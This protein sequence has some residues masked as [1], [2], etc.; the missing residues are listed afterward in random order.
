MNKNYTAF[1]DRMIKRYEGGYGWDRADPGGPTKYGVTCFDYAASKG[2]KMNSM[3]E[4]APRV[5][6]MSLA[7]AEGIYRKKY[8]TGVAFDQL[9]GGSDCV[10]F[11]YGVNSG[12]SRPV[13]VAQALVKQKQ[14]GKMSPELV[15][16]INKL[17]AKWFVKAMNQERLA[18]MH[19][20]RGGSAWATFGKGWGARVSDL[21]KYAL[22]IA[23][24]VAVL[25]PMSGPVD[26]PGKAQEPTPPSKGTVG[27]TVGGGTAGGTV[28]AASG[29]PW[30]AVIATVAAVVVVG[31]LVI[32]YR[33]YK[34]HKVNTTVVLPEH[35]GEPVLKT[36]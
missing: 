3:A 17:D 35:I 22:A 23:D 14:T 5:K 8:A 11:D 25:P 28:A 27:G 34:A 30:W 15:E 18:F 26:A 33:R 29:F 4:W 32:S 1:V 16:A 13:R 24:N 7:E 12:V 19:R 6:S 21:T 2:Q 10:M 9:E 36:A 31:L 20:I